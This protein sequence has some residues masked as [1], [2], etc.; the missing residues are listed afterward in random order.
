MV[1]VEVSCGFESNG[2][3]SRPSHQSTA[4]GENSVRLE[5]ICYDKPLEGVILVESTQAW[6]LLLFVNT[7]RNSPGQSS[8]HQP[9]LQIRHR[10]LLIANVAGNHSQTAYQCSTQRCLLNVRN[11]EFPL[12]CDDTISVWYLRQYTGDR[13]ARLGL[14]QN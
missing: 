8:N 12:L 11:Y 14:F 4:I 3:I 6:I 5:T 9:W 1:L 2:R 13:P 10:I 7:G